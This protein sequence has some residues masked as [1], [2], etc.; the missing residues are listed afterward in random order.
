MSHGHTR[1]YP[2]L[3]LLGRLPRPLLE[4][5]LCLILDRLFQ[6]AREQGELDFITGKRLEIE[7]TDVAQRLHLRLDRRGFT[8]ANPLDR[9]HIRVRGRTDAFLDLAGGREDADALFFQRRLS[10]QG[11]AETIMHTKHFLDAF[12]PPAWLQRL[13]GR[14]ETSVDTA[15]SSF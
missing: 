1:P 8:P 14:S 4:H 13:L 2:P 11:D 9:P 5:G 3:A 6:A 12:E 15:D 10:I 7:L